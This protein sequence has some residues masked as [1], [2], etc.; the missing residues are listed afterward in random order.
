MIPPSMVSA[1]GGDSL[2][3]PATMQITDA[4]GHTLPVSGS[5]FIL[6]T[7]LDKGT[8]AIRRTKQMAYLCEKTRDLVLSREAM[9]VLG[10][11]AASIDARQRCGRSRG[12]LRYLAPGAW[13][14]RRDRGSVDIRPASVTQSE[15]SVHTGEP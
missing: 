8:G 6:I 10:M 4:G 2:V 13:R 7:R 14:A 1:M 15:S 3:D 11:V 9:T 5:I 12:V